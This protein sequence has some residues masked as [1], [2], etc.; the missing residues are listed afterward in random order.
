MRGCWNFK[1]E[2]RP[3]FQ[4]L[5]QDISQQVHVERNDSQLHFKAVQVPCT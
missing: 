3:S 5:V 2:D 1:P 4:A